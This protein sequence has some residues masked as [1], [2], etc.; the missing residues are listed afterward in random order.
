[1]HLLI[2]T[3]RNASKWRN[4][5]FLNAVQQLTISNL[6]VFLKEHGM[7]NSK[8]LINSCSKHLINIQVVKSEFENTSKRTHA[9]D[10]GRLSNI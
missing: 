2:A 6:Q 4:G 9:A 7:E 1:M 10:G 3:Q 5:P 8:Q